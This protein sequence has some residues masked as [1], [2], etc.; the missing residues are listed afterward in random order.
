MADVDGRVALGYLL[1]FYGPLLTEHRRELARLYCEEDL[2]LSEIA[3]QLSITRQGVSDAIRKAR[4]Q[5][6]AYEEK[7]G[8]AARYLAIVR[9]A[10][11]CAEALDALEAGDSGALAS[12]RQA[13]ENILRI[14]R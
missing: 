10:R 5:L 12:A 9:Q 6:E 14:E 11:A 1:D 4:A 2:S 8:L 13:L 7:L 3:E